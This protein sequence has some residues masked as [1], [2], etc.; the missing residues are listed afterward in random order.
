MRAKLVE[1]I[2]HL[3][4]KSKEE[5]KKWVMELPIDERLMQAAIHNIEFSDEEMEQY[6]KELYKHIMTAYS[7]HMRKK[8]ARRWNIELTPE[9]L[10]KIRKATINELKKKAPSQNAKNIL[11]LKCIKFWDNIAN[12]EEKLEMILEIGA[13]I[14]YLEGRPLR[15]AIEANDVSLIKFLLQH[16]ANPTLKNRLAIKTAKKRYKDIEND[17][18]FT[19]KKER[20]LARIEQMIKMFR[21]YEKNL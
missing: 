6:N 3:S 17:V 5:I 2:K 12:D 21:D 9:D 18:Y 15:I 11:L 19:F 1:G 10:K 4:P 20:D 8:A 16:G 13:D 14:N 7:P